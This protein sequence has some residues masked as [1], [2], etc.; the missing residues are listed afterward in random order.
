MVRDSRNGCLLCGGCR[1]RHG[2]VP[3]SVRPRRP[4]IHR[5]ASGLAQASATPSRQ[6]P[7]Q[8]SQSLTGLDLLG[9]DAKDAPAQCRGLAELLTVVADA[10]APSMATGDERTAINLD[11]DPPR[12]E[13]QIEPPPPRRVEAVFALA[14]LSPATTNGAELKEQPRT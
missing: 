2:G 6:R 3:C 5:G 10:G 8:P 1:R 11:R 7:L 14:C 9:Q 4:N 12:R 13:G